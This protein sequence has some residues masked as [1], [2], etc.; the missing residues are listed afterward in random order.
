MKTGTLVIAIAVTSLIGFTACK[1]TDSTAQNDKDEIATT[2]EL[3]TDQ[4][5][6]DNLTEDANDIFMNAA[7]EKGLTE[8][9]PLEPFQSTGVLGCAEVTVSTTAGFPKTI[10]IDFKTGCTD[11]H[12]ITRKGKINI[13]LSDFLRKK[14]STAVLTFDGYYVNDFKKEG[15]ITWTNNSTASVKGWERKVENG[16]ITAPT[17]KY[18]MHSGIKNV[19]QTAGYDT[20][21]NL[22]DDAYSVTGNNSVTNSN[23][24]TRTSAILIALEKRTICE[25]ISKGSIELKG[26]KHS[27]IVDFGNGDCDKVATIAIDGGTPI[28]FL[29]R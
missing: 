5:I 29:L 24:I 27:A 26:P 4:A 12:G 22:L 8:E 9:R 21:L 16:K 1:K 17:G 10:V 13:I 28:T 20:P 11:A 6:S 23:N 19:V 18:W 25:N 15:T 3:S 14:G 2:I 7:T